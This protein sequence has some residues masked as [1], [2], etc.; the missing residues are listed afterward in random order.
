M[1]LK[2]LFGYVLPRD[3]NWRDTVTVECSCG[4]SHRLRPCAWLAYLKTKKWCP[5]RRTDE[6]S[7]DYEPQAASAQ[8]LEELLGEELN[9]IIQKD[10]SIQLLK[11]LGFDTLELQIRRR[12][13]GDKMR[14]QGI[15]EQ[16]ATIVARVTEEDLGILVKSAPELSEIVAIASER[17]KTQ[18]I[19]QRNQEFG[20]AI[21]R[22]VEQIF[23]DLKF[24]VVPVYKGYDFEAYYNGDVEIGDLGN[25]ELKTPD[26]FYL[27][28][29][30]ATRGN[31]IRMTEVQ[32]RVAVDNSDFYILCIVDLGD[33]DLTE[34][35]NQKEFQ[36]AVKQKI[37]ILDG[38]GIKLA[39]VITTQQPS[40]DEIEVEFIGR[41]RYLIK[42]S[43]W[44]REGDSLEQWVAMISQ[45]LTLP[46]KPDIRASNL[47][48]TQNHPFPSV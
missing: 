15:R 34:F 10:D 31:E 16:L 30:K 2:F 13:E 28:E 24:G 23:H 1:F 37:I 6:E 45:R 4:K 25:I 22:I 3:S 18:R 46:F 48:L 19:V 7:E 44:V 41:V 26:H 32:A 5:V 40:P 36:I 21:Q 17:L 20:K 8:N 9:E 12:S 39:P 35:K 47:C 38:I 43:L 27:V 29:V 42:K 33:K 14:E 11:H